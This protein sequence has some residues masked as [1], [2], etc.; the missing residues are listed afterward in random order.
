MRLFFHPLYNSPLRERK[1]HTGK[2]IAV[3]GFYFIVSAKIICA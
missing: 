1:S 3:Y 2:N